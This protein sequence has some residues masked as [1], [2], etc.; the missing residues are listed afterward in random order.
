MSS[1][2]PREVSNCVLYGLV[3]E[4]LTEEVGG[5][6]VAKEWKARNDCSACYTTHGD[7]GDQSDFCLPLQLQI[8]N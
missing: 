4:V 6:E 3:E 8:P 7:Q 5:V 2:D 1:V